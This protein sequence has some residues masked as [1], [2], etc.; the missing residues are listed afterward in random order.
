MTVIHEHNYQSVPDESWRDVAI[1]A[2]KALQFLGYPIVAHCFPGEP[3]FDECG[4]GW[5][6]HAGALLLTVKAVAEH[7]LGHLQPPQSFITMIYENEVER[8]AHDCGNP[9]GIDGIVQGRRPQ[10]E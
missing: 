4:H 1:G 2:R 7:Q 9:A 8:L 10:S 5:A 3:G 6:D